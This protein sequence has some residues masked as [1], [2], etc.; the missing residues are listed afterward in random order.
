MLKLG[1]ELGLEL[2]LKLGLELGL[3]LELELE[4]GLELNAT[5]TIGA[6]CKTLTPAPHEKSRID[7]ITS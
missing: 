7:S 3:V 6:S 4:L 2:G 1:L 5:E